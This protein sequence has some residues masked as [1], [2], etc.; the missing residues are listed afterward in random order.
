MYY[1]PYRA[2]LK[3]EARIYSDSWGIAATNYEVRYTHPIRERMILEIK[4]RSYSQTQADFYSDLFSHQQEL[5][6]AGRDKELSTYSTSNFGLGITYDIKYKLPFTDKQSISLFWDFMA[7]DYENFLDACA[8]QKCAGR[9]DPTVV[10]GDE[11]AYSFQANVLRVF[12]S[13]YY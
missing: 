7:F 6:F 10:V 11:P 8:S 13:V 2:S 5:N 9:K 12:F 1:L 4:A 3:L